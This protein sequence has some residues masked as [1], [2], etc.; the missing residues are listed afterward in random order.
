VEEAEEPI[1][2]IVVDSCQVRLRALLL[3]TQA[4]SHTHCCWRRSAAALSLHKRV[5]HD[6]VCH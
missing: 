4:H 1:E 3:R 2:A 6:V 5:S